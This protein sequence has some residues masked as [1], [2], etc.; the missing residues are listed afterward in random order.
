MFCDDYRER[1]LKEVWRA[2]R[3]IHTLLGLLSRSD[4]SLSTSP[5]SAAELGALVDA[6]TSQRLTGTEGK[7]LLG[8]FVAGTSSSASPPLPS[9]FAEVLDSMLASRPAPTPSASTESSSGT[10]LPA[11]AGGAADEALT[12]LVDDVIASHPDE[13]AKIRKGQLKVVKRLVGE[14]M[15]RSK[16]RADAKRVEEMV[17]EKLSGP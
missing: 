4:R 2:D 9:T 10:A 5:V 1:R 15:K 6:V 14:S 7:A 3:L 11:A 12:A 17:L 13:A 16:G 8:D